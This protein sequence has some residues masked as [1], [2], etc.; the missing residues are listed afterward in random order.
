VNTRRSLVVVGLAMALAAIA[1]PGCAK[2]V[3]QVDASYVS[4]EG[5]PSANARIIVYPDVAQIVQT[6]EDNIPEGPDPGDVLL[7]EAE[8]R[9]SGAGAI[10]GAILDGTAASGYEVLRRESNGGFRSIKDFVLTPTRRWID[11][12]WEIYRWTDPTPSG[13]SPATYLGRGVVSGA[14]T[15]SSPL[16]NVGLLSSSTIAELV[17]TGERA[18]FDS[19]ITMAWQ[20]VPGV[21][22]YWLQVY[23]NLGG[24]EEEIRSGIP[25]PF[26]TTTVREFFVAYVTAPADSFKIGRDPGQVLL[27]RTLLTGIEYLVRVSAV[28]GQGRLVATTYGD[29]EVQAG[30]GSYDVYRLGAVKVQPR[31]RTT[32]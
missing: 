14:V 21:A 26:A 4:P 27:R 18:P 28:D 32:P 29:F 13:F 9:A 15:G 2:K 24:T 22:G 20:A 7:S 31:R 11:S 1:A 30:L 3:T 6:F 25:A 16:T 23:Q 10:H 5:T 19:L 12:Q 8:V 17:Y